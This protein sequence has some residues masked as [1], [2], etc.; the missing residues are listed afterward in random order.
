VCVGQ[1]GFLVKTFVRLAGKK[2]NRKEK[3]QAHATV[4]PLKIRLS[5]E[6]PETATVKSETGVQMKV[7]VSL[8]HV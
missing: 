6:W 4:L 3:E 7:A 2:K 8:F 1:D 5:G